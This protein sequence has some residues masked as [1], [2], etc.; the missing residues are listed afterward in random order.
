VT[1]ERTVVLSD[2]QRT[3]LETHHAAAMI[4]VAQDG[5][6]RTA[7]VGVALVD[8]QVWSSGT[9]G[10]VRTSRLR[11][12]PRCTLFVFDAG[13]EWLALETHVT[14]HDGPDAPQLN[15]RLFRI[16][17]GRPSGPLSWFAGELAEP[18]FLTTMADEGRLV[19]EFD[20]LRAYGVVQEGT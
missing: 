12:D 14:I 3:F 4:T 20:V 16:M 1:E 9:R 2:S 13:F 18:E 15:L 10:R 5:T 17:Q 19:Y 11:A 8:G 7:R 6:P